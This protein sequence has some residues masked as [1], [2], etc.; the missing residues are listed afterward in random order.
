MGGCAWWALL[1]G[2]SPLDV[3]LDASAAPYDS[4][5]AIAWR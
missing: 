2:P 1:G 3:V 5:Y 4:V